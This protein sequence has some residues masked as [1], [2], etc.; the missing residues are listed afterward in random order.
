MNRIFALVFALS[1]A[2]CATVPVGIAAAT[3]ASAFG[4]SRH[5]V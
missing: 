2:I 4:G 1:L 3:T 5:C